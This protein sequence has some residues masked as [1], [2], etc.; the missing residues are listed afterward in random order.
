MAVE[1]DPNTAAVARQI[2]DGYD[3]RYQQLMAQAKACIQPGLHFFQQKFSVQ[4]Y[5]TVSA[6]KVASSDDEKL[7]WW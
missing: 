2:A 6:F 1:H 3:A 5:G 7:A 4:F